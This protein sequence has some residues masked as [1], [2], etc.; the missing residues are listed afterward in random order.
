MSE[1]AT[2][3]RF[4]ESDQYMRG[5]MARDGSYQG[6]HLD[7]ALRYV[8]DWRCAIDGGAHVGTWSRLMAGRFEKVIAAEPSPD[9]FACLQANMASFGCSNVECRQ[10]ALGRQPG[11]VSMALDGKEVLRANTGA[12]YVRPGGE[13]ACEPIDDWHLPALG[14]LKLDVEGSELAALCGALETL[15]RCRPIVLFEAKGFGK[16]RYGEVIHAVPDFLSQIRYRKL[17]AIS[18]D[19]IWGPA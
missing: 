14:F 5:E 12:R 3:W 9:T 7:V 2:A 11:L 16:K 19:E 18:R 13:I 4:P 10:L 6:T 15:Y 8:T 17:D 1:Q